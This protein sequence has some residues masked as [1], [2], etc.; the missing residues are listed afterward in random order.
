MLA[1]NKLNILAQSMHSFL[2]QNM[3]RCLLEITAD[4]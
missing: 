3:K 1:Q 2:V 4:N